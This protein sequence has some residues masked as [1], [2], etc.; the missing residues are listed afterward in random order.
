MTTLNRLHEAQEALHKLIIGKK[1]VKVQMNG[2]SVE[3]TPSN[4]GDLEKY[5]DQLKT[6]LNQGT[7]RR[8]ARVYL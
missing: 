5:I 6:E 2:R 7:Q 3:F 8:A 1:A 4:R